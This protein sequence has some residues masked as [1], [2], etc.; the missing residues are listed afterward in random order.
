[1]LSGALFSSRPNNEPVKD[2]YAPGAVRAELEK[3]LDQLGREQPEIPLVIGGK[4]VNTGDLAEVR[5]PHDHGKILATFHQAGPREVEQA[6]AAAAEAWKTWS[7]KPARQRLAV[8]LRAA[9]LLATK[10]RI[11]LVAATMLNQSKTAYQAEIDATCELIDFYRLNSYFADQLTAIQPETGGPEINRMELRPLEGFVFAVSPFNFTAIGGNLPAAPAM[12]GNVVL[13]KP[14]STTVFSNYQLLEIWKEAGLPDGVIN[15]I[16]GKGAQVGPAVFAQKGLAGIHFTGSTDTF[17]R[18]WSEV[19]QRIADYN[20]FPRLVG[21]TGGKDFVVA[22]PSADPLAV[23]AGLIRAA[24]EYR[25]RNAP[26]PPGPICPRACGPGSRR[27]WWKRRPRSR[28]ATWPTLT[29]SWARSSTGPPSTRSRATWTWP[30]PHRTAR[31][32][33]AEK[34]TTPRAILSGPRWWRPPIP[35]TASWKRRSS[36]R[37]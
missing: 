22:H 27:S 36:A 30:P 17:R 23:S 11:R 8:F 7:V 13:W 14:A 19:G 33:W 1:M 28:W 6:V 9:E 25:A 31:S 18:M 37:C 2:Y 16:P 21:E 35:I 32:W 12:M 34:P 26:P 5:C 3:T 15:F 29:T 4:E 10:Y 20:T 24:F